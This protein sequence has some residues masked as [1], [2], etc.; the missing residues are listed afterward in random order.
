MATIRP[1]R[2]GVLIPTFA[3]RTEDDLGIGDTG[4]VRELID[5]AADTGLGFVQFLP[6]N[7]TGSDSSP[8]NAISSVA[9]D[10]LTLDLNPRAVPE[11]DAEFFHETTARFGVEQLR[12]GAILAR[13]RTQGRTAAPRLWQAARGDEAR[14]GICGFPKNGGSVAGGLLPVPCADGGEWP[15]GLDKLA[16][17]AEHSGEGA[18]VARGGAAQECAE[19]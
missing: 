11:L 13:A 12:S 7:A 2:A 9:L 10:Y 17:L 16:G 4:G 14:A 19:D 5:W 15:R 8:Y 1:R 6:I 18:Q 3:I